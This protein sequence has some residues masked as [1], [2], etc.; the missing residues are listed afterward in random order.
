MLLLD[1]LVNNSLGDMS[2]SL[3]TVYE[4]PTQAGGQG[5]YNFD[6]PEEYEIIS[7]MPYCNNGGFYVFISYLNGN[8]I[9][10]KLMSAG[11]ASTNVSVGLKVFVK[12]N[13]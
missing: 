12:I 10:V 9:G 13:N 8:S 5:T 11:G 6:I 1:S 2:A 4:P 3:P 7:A